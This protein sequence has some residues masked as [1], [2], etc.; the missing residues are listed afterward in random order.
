[1]VPFGSISKREIEAPVIDGICL[2]KKP[3]AARTESLAINEL[4]DETIYTVAFSEKCLNGQRIGLVI[5][6][7]DIVDQKY[8]MPMLEEYL[9]CNSE[10]DIDGQLDGLEF[11]IY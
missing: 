5:Q 11:N 1:M 7:Y 6:D 4:G 8:L 3:M 2:V 9:L 10:L